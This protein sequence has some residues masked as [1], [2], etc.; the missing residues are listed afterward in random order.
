[1]CKV[2]YDGIESNDFFEEW[3]LKLGT[4]AEKLCE[5]CCVILDSFRKKGA[6]SDDLA[7]RRWNDK[8]LEVREGLVSLYDNYS[9]HAFVFEK[10]SETKNHQ[11]NH[12]Y[13][14]T[15]KTNGRGAIEQILKKNFED[16]SAREEFIGAFWDYCLNENLFVNVEYIAPICQDNFPIFHL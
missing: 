14:H 6:I 2:V 9:P 1:M 10:N 7:K 11:Y 15:F 3:A 8:D 13:I 16:K 4:S 5:L 12:G